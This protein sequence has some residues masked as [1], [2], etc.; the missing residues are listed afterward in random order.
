MITPVLGDGVSSLLMA[1]E[2]SG[3]WIVVDSDEEPL[4]VLTEAGSWDTYPS[5]KAKTFADW[6]ECADMAIFQQA[7][8]LPLV[9]VAR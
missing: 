1:H 3:P 7:D 6:D 4:L 9:R 8:I 2:C 5:A